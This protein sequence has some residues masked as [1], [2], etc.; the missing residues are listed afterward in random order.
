[1]PLVDGIIWTSYSAD[2][3]VRIIASS[4]RSLSRVVLETRTLVRTRCWDPYQ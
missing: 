1:M 2:E 3:A 4:S